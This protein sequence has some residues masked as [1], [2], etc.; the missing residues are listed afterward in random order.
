MS[1][2]PRP[3]RCGA[4]CSY[5]ES[6]RLAETRLAEKYLETVTQGN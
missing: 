2:T 3:S 4:H 6:T 5:E 1:G